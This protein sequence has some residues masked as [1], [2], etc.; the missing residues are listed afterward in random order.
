MSKKLEE[1]PDSDTDIDSRELEILNTIL[2]IK[3]DNPEEYSKLRFV[4]YATAIFVLLS[5]PFT[6]RIIELSTPSAT[7]WLIL[8]IIKSIIFFMLYYIVVYSTLNE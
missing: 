6:D 1:L 5:L 3:T 7:S 4:F 2:N 8:L